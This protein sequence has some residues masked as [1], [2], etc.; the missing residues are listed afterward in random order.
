[1]RIGLQAAAARTLDDHR[2]QGFGILVPARAPPSR[3]ARS[4]K[5]VPAMLT[6]PDTIV[7][8]V[9]TTIATRKIAIVASLTNSNLV[10]VF[11][12]LGVQGS[13][14]TVYGAVTRL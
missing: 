13:R 10:M 6:E 1:V 3:I 9:S 2:D 12:R 8:M 4:R 11:L 14:S 5:P 7:T